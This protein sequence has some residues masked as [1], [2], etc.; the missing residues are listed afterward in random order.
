M[1]EEWLHFFI[2]LFS[3]SLTFTLAEKRQKVNCLVD[4]V[5]IVEQS[6]VVSLGSM[7]SENILKRFFK[8]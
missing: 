8:I 6:N 2:E 1:Y 7:V 5:D 4:P 3:S